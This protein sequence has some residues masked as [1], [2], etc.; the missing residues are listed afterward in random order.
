MKFFLKFFIFVFIV[1][2]CIFFWQVWNNNQQTEAVTKKQ[3]NQRLNR[4]ITWLDSNY[5]SVEN[6]DNPIL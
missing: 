5:S 1:I 6:T 4:S 3:I 2:L